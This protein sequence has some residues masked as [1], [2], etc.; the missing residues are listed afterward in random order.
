MRTKILFFF[1]KGVTTF[2]RDNIASWLRLQTLELDC[3]G[4]DPSSTNRNLDSYLTSPCLNLNELRHV[5]NLEPCLA[6]SKS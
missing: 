3:L 1:F 6:C 4:S 2:I 5:R